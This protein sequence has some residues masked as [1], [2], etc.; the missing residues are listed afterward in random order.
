MTYRPLLAFVPLLALLAAPAPAATPAADMQKV[1]FARDVAPILLAQCQTCHGPE[2]AKGKY[3]VDTY[4]RLMT[5]GSSGDASVTPGA[6][7][8]SALYKLLVTHD[9][10]ERMPKKADPLPKAQTEAIRLWIAQGAAFDGP[11]RTAQ[12]SSYAA[13]TSGP[14]TAPAAYPRPVPITA[15]AFS[16]GGDV[17]Y[18]GGYHE[19]TRWDPKTG[20]LLGRT[21]LPIE[22]VQ[23][24]AVNPKD[25]GELAAAGGTPG[26]SGELLI[27]RLRPKKHDAVERVVRTNDVIPAA[28]FSPSGEILAAGGADGTVRLFRT[29]GSGLVW[30]AEPHADWVTDLAFSPDGGLLATASRD[31]S[32][33]VFDVKSGQAE[34]SYM[35]QPEPVY[36]ATFAADGKTVLTAG[37]DRKLHQ[38]SAKDGTKVSVTGGFEGDVVRLARLG[39]DVWSV[40]ADGKVRSHAIDEGEKPKEPAAPATKPATKPTSKP[41]AAAAAD[42]KKKPAPSAR[43]LRRT[44]ETSP[45]WLY[46]VTASEPAGLVAAAGHDGKV[47]VYAA[48]DGKPVAEFVAAPGYKP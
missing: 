21:P 17:L 2:K 48:A 6:S 18:A 19:L 28:R 47:H 38:W 42:T 43:L 29:D 15:L 13:G 35:D 7:D 14:T 45:E 26:V 44:I 4:D 16:P 25:A 8:R 32:C 9:A 31:K 36:A 39:N 20:K 46:A 41:A 30:S 3:R 40:G 22:R 12:V 24:I 10:D 37:R 5:P 27:V 1:S 33:R 34:A 11:S 23:A